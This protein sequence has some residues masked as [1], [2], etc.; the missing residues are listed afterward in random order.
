MR[1]PSFFVGGYRKAMNCAK[2]NFCYRACD[3]IDR[4]ADLQ[5]VFMSMCK[6]PPRLGKPLGQSQLYE[7]GSLAGLGKP[8]GSRC[9]IPAS[10]RDGS[11]V[12]F[13]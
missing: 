12:W 9:C 11:V 8:F 10:D 5:V 4:F 7:I 2:I 3:S 6:K 13:E 1:Q